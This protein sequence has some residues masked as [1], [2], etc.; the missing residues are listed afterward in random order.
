MSPEQFLDRIRDQ[1]IGQPVSY[2]RLAAN[3]LF[4]YVGCEPGD[5]GRRR[6]GLP[7]APSNGCDARNARRSTEKR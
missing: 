3:S 2:R 4:G 5:Y 6:L 1:V 7:V